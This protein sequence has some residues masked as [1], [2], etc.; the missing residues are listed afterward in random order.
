MILP[1]A[2]TNYYTQM[3]LNTSTKSF[4]RYLKMNAVKRG[5]GGNPLGTPSQL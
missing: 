2:V 4:Q 1:I 5:F 3:I